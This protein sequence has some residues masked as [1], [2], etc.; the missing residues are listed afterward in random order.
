MQQVMERS[1][2]YSGTREKAIQDQEVI[3]IIRKNSKAFFA[4]VRNDLQ[5]PGLPV[6]LGPIGL[7]LTNYSFPYRDAVNNDIKDLSK[8][9]NNIYL[10]KT[11]DF[12]HLKDTIH[13]DSRSQRLMGKR[14]ANAVYKNSP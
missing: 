7:Y 9:G 2:E 5:Q 3:L 8:P 6:Y 13:F 12:G 4:K 10:I 1:K 11:S 14:F